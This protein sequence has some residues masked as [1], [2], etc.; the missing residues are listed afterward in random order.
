MKTTPSTSRED[1]G[2]TGNG[3]RGRG[4]EQ[5]RAAVG[6]TVAGATMPV[7]GIAKATGAAGAIKNMFEEGH[8]DAGAKAKATGTGSARR[9]QSARD[10]A[11]AG[12]A[13]GAFRNTQSN[14]TSTRAA[15]APATRTNTRAKTPEYVE[16]STIGTAAIKI[17]CHGT[18]LWPIVAPPV[19]TDTVEPITA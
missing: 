2:R 13:R 4:R 11:R 16:S 1:G 12:A 14:L 9:E 8:G 17:D 6:A 5:P 15:P 18:S 3:M 10:R 19:I 7:A